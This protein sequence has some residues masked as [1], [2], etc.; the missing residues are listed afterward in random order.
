MKYRTYAEAK[1]ANPDNE[2]VTTGKRWVGGENS[3]G[4]FMAINLSDGAYIFSEHSWVICD[5]ADHL[6]NLKDFLEDGLKLSVGDAVMSINRTISIVKNESIDSWNHCGVNAN[7][8]FILSASA[9]NGGSK[10]PAK[11]EQWTVYNNT[12]PL[13]ELTDEQ[14]AMLFNAWRGGCEVEALQNAKSNEWIYFAMPM[15]SRGEV[16]RIKQKSER[17]T[18]IDKSLSLMTSETE[19]TMEQMFGAQFDAGARYKDL[20]HHFGE[21]I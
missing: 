18:F 12:L 17:E 20:T 13:C 10:I 1:I 14:A 19:R 9:L 8:F 21:N 15:F 6:L 5:P 4:A 7:H 16:Y 2:I 3:D 11:A